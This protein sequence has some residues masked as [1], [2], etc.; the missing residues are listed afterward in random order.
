M[1]RD[2]LRTFRQTQ[3]LGLGTGFS[4]GMGAPILGVYMHISWSSF[5]RNG[6]LWP[7][8]PL[9]ADEGGTVC[10]TNLPL[11][12]DSAVGAVL[13]RS[14]SPSSVALR[15][16]TLLPA[17]HPSGSDTQAAGRS[18]SPSATTLREQSLPSDYPQLP[19]LG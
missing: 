15:L 1:A 18:I 9:H 19:D 2:A 13:V 8:V 10:Q 4:A 11:N 5:F 14:W 17:T 12:L 3:I 16:I 7:T 6:K